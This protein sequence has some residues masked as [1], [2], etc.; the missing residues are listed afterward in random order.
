F[1]CSRRKLPLGQTINAI[2]LDDRQEWHVTADDM[3]EL[4]HAD[5]AAVAITADG[6]RLHLAICQQRPR[7]HGWHTSMH[8][9]KAMRTAKEIS[10]GLARAANAAEL[11]HFVLLQTHFIDST[12]D[13]VRNRVVTAS[14]A[15]GALTA[16]ISL[17]I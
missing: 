7:C 1:I 14:G 17:A 10:R 8:C 15:E 13:L 3:L 6:D 5:T 2:I 11:H 9:I 4:P 12:D 16:S